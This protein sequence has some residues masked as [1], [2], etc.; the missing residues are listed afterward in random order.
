VDSYGIYK[1]YSSYNA[2]SRLSRPWAKPPLMTSADEL[3]AVAPTLL[4]WQSYDPEVKA[5]LSSTAIVTADGLFLFDPIPLG[6]TAMKQLLQ[7]R[8]LAGVIVTNANHVRASGQFAEQ[9]DLSIFAHLESFPDNA[10]SR[11][12]EIEDGTRIGNSLEVIAIEGAVPGEIALNSSGHDAALIVGDALINFE[13][14]GFT[15]LP[16]KY[17]SNQK[18][19]RQSLRKLLGRKAERIL[20][21]HGTPILSQ[22]NARLQQ[23][24]D[25]ST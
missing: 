16:R 5:D 12:T 1:T 11:F 20:F 13:P 25:S 3:Q 9:F 24:L 2:T 7:I 4:F 14:Y 8:S 18:Q 6:E 22:A 19:M 15:F 10:P 23:L 17:C 21:A